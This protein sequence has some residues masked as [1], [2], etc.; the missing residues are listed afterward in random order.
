MSINRVMITGNLT[1]DP[2]LRSTGSGMSVLKLRVAVNDR[3]KNAT[4]G[5]WEDFPNYFDVTTF[6]GRAEGLAKIL[7]KG[8][9]IA[10]DGKLR[11]REWESPAGEKRSGVEIIADDIEPLSPREGGGTY[12]PS[13]GVSA[14]S[15]PAGDL[16]GEE[17]PF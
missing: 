9:K 12:E 2:E 10:V 16:D 11:W 4:S 7:H 13:G 3:R 1:K 8:S 14:G 6:A 5:E 15:R 17:I